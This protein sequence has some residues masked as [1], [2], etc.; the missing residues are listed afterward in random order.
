M[1]RHGIDCRVVER[2]PDRPGD[3]LALNLPGNAVAVL[4]RL[5]A[6]QEVLDGGV[7]VSRREYRTSG[8]RLTFAIDEA[9]FWSEVAP[10]VCAPHAVVLDALAEGVNIE[11][12]LGVTSVDRQ[13][14]GR[15][16]VT[17]SRR[18]RGACG[19]R[20]GGGRRPLHRCGPW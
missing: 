4:Q 20:R 10:S 17:T 12:G 6:A 5:G 16:R 1:A 7:L 3:G 11:R 8:D 9:T 19:A 15:V 13:Q 2:R 14:D 18:Q